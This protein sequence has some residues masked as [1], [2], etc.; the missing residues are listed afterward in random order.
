[1]SKKSLGFT[2][3]ELIIVVAIIGILAA[4]A[5]VAINPAKRVGDTYNAR[6]WADVTAI[7]DAI[8]T[9]VVDNN[10]NF[11][12]A[13]VNITNATAGTYVL[14][15]IAGVGAG[16]GGGCGNAANIYNGLANGCGNVFSS[17][18]SLA[19][20]ITGGAA[21]NCIDLSSALVDT[22]L[23]TIPQDPLVSGQGNGSAS[24]TGYYIY[25]A[26]TSNRITVGACLPYNNTTI[27]VAK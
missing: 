15:N 22:Y 14:G 6:R 26:N 2:L 19:T 11:P 3:I 8:M 16:T 24:W 4:A 10:G 1:M 13:L 12:A 18:G 5:F 17:N 23:P 20:M 25:K 7:L 9:Y 27:R 21:T